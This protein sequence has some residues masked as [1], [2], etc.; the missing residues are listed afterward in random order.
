[1]WK[2]VRILLESEE[3]F[4]ED[5][6]FILYSETKREVGKDFNLGD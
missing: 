5:E 1:L 6:H 3:L 2:E 4:E